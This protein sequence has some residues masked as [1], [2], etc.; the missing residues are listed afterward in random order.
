QPAE[1][2]GWV[3]APDQPEIT[4]Y[5]SNQTG[6][7]QW[8][9]YNTKTRT[10]QQLTHHPH[11]AYIGFI[12]RD[13]KKF[14][15]WQDPTGGEEGKWVVMST[16]GSFDDTPLIPDIPEAYPQGAVCG[17]DTVVVGLA[18]VPTSRGKKSYKLCVIRNGRVICSN[19][20]V[21]AHT[22]Y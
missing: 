19:N 22:V 2:T 11:G 3:C 5:R 4:I 16:E 6:E 15:W 18:G 12:S 17:N 9:L 7:P 10:H 1:M 20:H 13:G 21:S 8:Y 14:T